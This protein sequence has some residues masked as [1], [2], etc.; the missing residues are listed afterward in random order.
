[1]LGFHIERE[2][3]H[4]DS[5]T[6]VIPSSICAIP[7]AKSVRPKPSD[8]PVQDEFG[9]N[10]TLSFCIKSNLK[11]LFGGYIEAR[12]V[13]VIYGQLQQGNKHVESSIL[14]WS[15]HQGIKGLMSGYGAA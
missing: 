15:T 13:R 4:T 11:E 2:L 7:W 5:Y 3:G 1:M 12:D 6:L 8:Q 10:L 9:G 14:T